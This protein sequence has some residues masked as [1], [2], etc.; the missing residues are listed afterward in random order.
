MNRLKRLAI[1]RARDN[2]KLVDSITLYGKQDTCITTVCKPRDLHKVQ[3]YR[4]LD[5][6]AVFQ[7]PDLAPRGTNQRGTVR[8]RVST[9]VSFHYTKTG[10]MG[11]SG[12]VLTGKGMSKSEVSPSLGGKNKCYD[13]AERPDT[14]TPLEENRESARA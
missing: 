10:I 4:T 12:G 2:A 8:K 13:I 3:S 1:K 5:N 7:H 6:E 11:L 9:G 14:F